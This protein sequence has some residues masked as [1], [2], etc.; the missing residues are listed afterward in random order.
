M[1]H[2]DNPLWLFFSAVYPEIFAEIVPTDF[3]SAISD[4]IAE[5]GSNTFFS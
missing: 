5:F 1:S 4:G 2:R 3:F